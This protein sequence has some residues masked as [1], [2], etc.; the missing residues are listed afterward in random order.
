MYLEDVQMFSFLQK[1]LIR[2]SWF[3]SFQPEIYWNWKR[4]LK[5]MHI[6]FEIHLLILTYKFIIRVC[7]LLRKWSWLDKTSC[8]ILCKEGIW[9]QSWVE[10][11]RQMFCL[12][13]LIKVAQMY[14]NSI[15]TAVY[16][17]YSSKWNLGSFF[18]EIIKCSMYLRF[19]YHKYAIITKT[20]HVALFDYSNSW[21]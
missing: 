2:A 18:L 3:E 7:Q 10:S 9:W 1:Y 8:S 20:I 6:Y 4:S 21:A 19:Q 11:F 14:H 15:A 12:T 16:I 13:H 5:L 17:Q